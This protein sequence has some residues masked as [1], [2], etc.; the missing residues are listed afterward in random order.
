MAATRTSTDRFD[1]NDARSLASTLLDESSDCGSVLEGTQLTVSNTDIEAV[2]EDLPD[3]GTEQ[4]NELARVLLQWQDRE[5]P[6]VDIDELPTS[7]TTWNEA[8]SVASAMK[9]LVDVGSEEVFSELQAHISTPLPNYQTAHERWE[10]IS[11]DD[12]GAALNAYARW[13]MDWQPQEKTRETSSDKQTEAS[14][15]DKFTPESR[16]EECANELLRTFEAHEGGYGDI[17]SE[18]NEEFDLPSL[19][20]ANVVV[21][22]AQGGTHEERVQDLVHWLENELDESERAGNYRPTGMH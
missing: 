6:D 1:W 19:G 3:E 4:V 9:T 5:N 11:T 7:V 21:V 8:R 22:N 20:R 17:F 14:P 15:Y 13:L 16:A 10:S 2:K 18:F 12:G